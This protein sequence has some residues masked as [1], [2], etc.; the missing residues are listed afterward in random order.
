MFFLAR[1]WDSQSSSTPVSGSPPS[2][3][4]YAPT[5]G[6]TITGVYAALVSIYDPDGDLQTVRLYVD[7]SAYASTNWSTGSYV[8]I[9]ISTSTLT[10]GGHSIYA[11]LADVSTNTA[12]TTTISVLVSNY[13][14]PDFGGSFIA[15]P[16]TGTPPVSISFTASISGSVA[17][18]LWDFLGTSVFVSTSTYLYTVAS[19]YSP[20]MRLIAGT[21]SIVDITNTNY[22]TLVPLTTGTPSVTWISWRNRL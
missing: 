14:P 1:W 6:E 9:S 11:Y 3:S 15:T 17:Q 5:D 12:Y 13:S 7:G 21:G 16:T 19:I 8:T 2:G 4:I 20:R 10:N 18:V 22:I